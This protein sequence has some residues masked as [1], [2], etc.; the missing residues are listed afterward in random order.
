[1]I[2]IGDILIRKKNNM[3]I[4]N[5]RSDGVKMHKH[6]GKEFQG[7]NGLAWYDNNAR[8]Y[9]CI[10]AR[11]TTQDP[12]AEK[13]PWLSP[14]NHCANNPLRYIDQNGDSI[15][16]LNLGGIIGHS[17]LLIQ[18]ENH[19]WK[20]YSM[21]G[22]NLYKLTD[23]KIGGKPYH[24][25]GSKIF[26]SPQEFLSSSYNKNGTDEQIKND[27]VNNYGYSEAYI[28]PTTREQDKIIEKEFIK[29]TKK[30]YNIILN[31]CAQVVRNSLKA[32]GLNVSENTFIYYDSMTNTGSTIKTEP[33]SPNGVFNTIINNYPNG[34][35]IR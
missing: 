20:Y 18:N 33:I 2:I 28:L 5:Y 17:A 6:T 3:I 4:S 22:N 7:F 34:L 9:D 8:Y 31:Q 19:K 21:N 10:L 27:E 24:D 14:Y 11:F 26:N 25:I 15:A 1:L 23:G 29:H 12:L 16:V 35:H 30:P 13:Y 32:A